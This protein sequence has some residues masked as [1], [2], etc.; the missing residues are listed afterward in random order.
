MLLNGI[1]A[2]CCTV[3]EPVKGKGGG[4]GTVTVTNFYPR[5]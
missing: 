1:V 4:P 2:L 3:G 5:A